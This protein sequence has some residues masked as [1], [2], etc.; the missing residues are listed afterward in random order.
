MIHVN[1]CFFNNYWVFLISR[2][3]REIGTKEHCYGRSRGNMIKHDNENEL[4]MTEFYALNRKQN[5]GCWK[6][7]VSHDIGSN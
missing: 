1:Y 4:A 6:F 5:V 3:L 2:A 7:L